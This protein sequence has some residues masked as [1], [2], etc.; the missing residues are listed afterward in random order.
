M[1]DTVVIDGEMSLFTSLDGDVSLILP[2]AGEMGVVTAFREYP[3]YTGPL[4]FTPSEEQQTID[5]A[6]KAVLENLVI[7]PIPNNYGLITWDGRVI[8]VS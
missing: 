1:F 6:G 2:E 7:N 4:E 5:A 3:A 8:T